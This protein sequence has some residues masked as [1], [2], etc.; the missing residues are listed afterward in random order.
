MSSSG[1]TDMLK[2]AGSYFRRLRLV[3]KFSFAVIFLL[4]VSSIVFN[5]LI[6]SHQRN[7][8]RA[9]MQKSHLGA[10]R[11]L[12]KDSIEPLIILDPLRLDELVRTMLQTP[13]CTYAGIVDRNNRIVA[14]TNR[15]KLGEQL[16]ALPS[17]DSSGSDYVI[18]E[19]SSGSVREI[20]VP[21]KVGYDLTGTVIAGFSP[22]NIENAIAA[23]LAGLKRY[24]LMI[25]LLIGSVGIWGAFGFA[26]ILTTPMRKVKEKMAQVQAGNLDLEIPGKEPVLCHKIMGCAE[27]TCPAFGKTRCWSISGTNCFGSQQGDVFNKLSTCRECKVYRESCGDEIG[28][29]IEVFNEMIG[30]L[31]TSIVEL[32]ESNREKSK[33]EKLSALGEMSMTVAHEIKN[34]LNSIQGA[35][36]YLRENFEGEVL[37]E[38]LQIIDEET[39][40]LNEIVTSI[41]RYSRP[42]PLTLQRGDLNQLIRETAALIRQEATDNNIEVLLSLHDTIPQFSFDSQQIKQALLNL[43]VNA[44]DATRPGDDIQICTR[45]AGPMVTIGIEDTGCG[46]SEETVANIFKPFY[47]TKTRGSGLGL[48]CVERI[49]KDHKG[50]ISIFSSVGNG[51]RIEISLPAGK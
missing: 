47:T 38:F 4:L 6:I 35:T 12:A 48:A 30:R 42:A 43:L 9:E 13:G 39:R 28:E 31:R 16:I 14:H 26:S 27:E 25:S 21:V 18:R 51:T 7:S 15:K 46:M 17:S 5:T 40:R 32:E 23:D 50:E 36:T 33:L 1:N 11:S 41:L 8:L 20:I 2:K 10:V 37:Q 49:V 3:Q 44:V 34:P 45:L 24:T 29:L 19:L 22:D